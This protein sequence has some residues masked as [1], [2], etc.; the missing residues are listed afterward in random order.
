MGW[1]GQG[2]GGNYS[3]LLD[4][5]RNV[6]LHHVSLYLSEGR[7]NHVF[8]MPVGKEEKTGQRKR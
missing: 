3:H 2:H 6:P 7:D 4:I 5:Y 1:G 8:S